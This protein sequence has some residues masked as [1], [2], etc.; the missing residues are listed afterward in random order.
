MR[1]GL[2]GWAATVNDLVARP[3]DRHLVESPVSEGF[4]GLLPAAAQGD[5]RNDNRR[6][7][8]HHFVTTRVTPPAIS[9]ETSSS[10]RGSARPPGDAR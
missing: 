8:A 4:L 9:E 3:H 2:T 7:D 1:I 5:E 10:T 6:S